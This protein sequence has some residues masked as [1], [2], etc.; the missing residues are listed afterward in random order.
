MV[1]KMKDGKEDEGW[2][3]GFELRTLTPFYV[4]YIFFLKYENKF[5]LIKMI[6]KM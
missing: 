6:F 3:S 5:I 1:K 2:Y 4:N